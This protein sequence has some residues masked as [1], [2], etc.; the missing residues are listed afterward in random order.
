MMAVYPTI[1]VKIPFFT[2][3]FERNM[4]G[5]PMFPA[6]T[7]DKHVASLKGDE[8]VSH[9]VLPARFD[10]GFSAIQQGNFVKLLGDDPSIF[11]M[12]RLDSEV[13]EIPPMMILHGQDDSAVPYQ[14]SKAFVDKAMKLHPEAKIFYNAVPG[15]EHG[16]DK[17]WTLETAELKEALGFITPLWLE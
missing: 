12:E 11:P 5:F 6:D 14:S 16:L 15:C 9:I 8:V 1:D 17:D 7:V 10:L 3:A 2:T 13:K 4:V